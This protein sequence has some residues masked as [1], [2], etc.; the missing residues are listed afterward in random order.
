M[1]KSGRTIGYV[2]VSSTDQNMARQLAVLDG[3]DVLFKDAMSGKNTNRKGLQDMLEFI[4][5][6]DTIIVK[7]ID[8]LARSTRDLLRIMDDLEERGVG[9]EFI[10]TPY[11][12]TTSKEGRFFITVLAALAELERSTILERQA[13]GIAAAKTRG[14]YEKDTKL[15]EEQIEEVEMRVANGDPKAQ[16]ARDLGISRQTLY[17]ALNRTGSYAK[18]SVAQFRKASGL[19]ERTSPAA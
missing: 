19:E 13:E 4:Q 1:D 10:D 3:V 9:V 7:S 5:E 14:I 11:L 16:I 6:G 15:S 2:R 18:Y 8:R 17:K 12:N